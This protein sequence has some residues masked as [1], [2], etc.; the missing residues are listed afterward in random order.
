MT[1][2]HELYVFDA[3]SCLYQVDPYLRLV[4][5][6]K[7]EAVTT[8]SGHPAIVYGSKDDDS[9]ALKSLSEIDVT[10]N[11]SREFFAA[12]IAK[13]LANLA[14][15]KH[16]SDLFKYFWL[17]FSAFTVNLS[18]CDRYALNSDLFSTV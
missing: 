8:D 10:G 12:E 5:D 6:R 9:S 3:V 7:L 1:Y 16:L 2:N 13:S 15:V 17:S 4:E 11:Q 18:L 14:N